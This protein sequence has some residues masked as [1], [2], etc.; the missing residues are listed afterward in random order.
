MC[1]RRRSLPA[2]FRLALVA[3]L[4]ALG[5]AGPIAAQSSGAAA[6][7]SAGAAQAPLGDRVG[8]RIPYYARVEPQV[9]TSGPLDQLGL[10]DDQGVG[11]RPILDLQSHTEAHEAERVSKR[12]VS[13]QSGADRGS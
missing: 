9:E 13:G 3:G 5:G 6:V 11:S 12:G 2:R 1:I 7:T 10:I 4:V 8:E